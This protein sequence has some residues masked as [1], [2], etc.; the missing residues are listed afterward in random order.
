[1]ER[2]GERMR[3]IEE[4]LRQAG[5]KPYVIPYG[6]SNAVGATAYAV[7]MVECMEQ[8][9]RLPAMPE[10]IVVASSSGGTQAGLVAGA[11]MTGFTGE[12]IGIG[13]DKGERGPGT[14]AE[15]VRRLAMETLVHLR[16]E[17][18]LADNAVI[19]NEEYLGDGYG[20]VG[21]LERNAI[22][23]LALREGMLL[24]PVY[25]GRA[26]GALMDMIG[27]GRFRKH[28]SILFWHTGGAPALFAYGPQVL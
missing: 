2:R 12:L 4:E 10:A 11:R 28:K 21:P 26:M 7:A 8:L 13:I 27:K 14:L 17:P 19:V 25:T 20:V 5:K 22:H 24:D 1:M 18:R 15:D 16:A 6:G 23:A 3:E 9:S